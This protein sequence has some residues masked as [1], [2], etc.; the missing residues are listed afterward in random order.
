MAVTGCG[1]DCNPQTWN[2]IKAP[3]NKKRPTQVDVAA[4][5]LLAG[6]HPTIEQLMTF[7][8][9]RKFNGRNQY[10]SQGIVTRGVLLTFFPAL[11]LRTWND[12]LILFSPIESTQWR[13]MKS[14][15]IFRVILKELRKIPRPE[16]ADC[17]WTNWYYMTH[18]IVSNRIILKESRN[19]WKVVFFFSASEQTKESFHN[20]TSSN[21]KGRNRGSVNSIE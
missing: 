1:T 13:G 9:A 7:N 18:S 21:W 5:T 11:L 10:K 15:G 14:R 17:W 20:C 19:K 8:A 2:N 16:S 3:E 6:E 12:F 4:T